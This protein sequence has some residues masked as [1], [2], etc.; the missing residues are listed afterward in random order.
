MCQQKAQHRH[1]FLI[2]GS[3][4]EQRGYKKVHWEKRDSGSETKRIGSTMFG[5]IVEENGTS[6]VFSCSGVYNL[7][8]QPTR[9]PSQCQGVSHVKLQKRNGTHWLQSDRRV[10]VDDKSSANALAG[11]TSVQVAPIQEGG[12]AS[13]SD[14]SVAEPLWNAA[15]AGRVSREAVPSEQ[16]QS[17]RAVEPDEWAVKVRAKPILET[18]TQRQR[19]IHELTH[20]YHLFLGVQHA[21]LEK[22][23]MILIRNSKTQE[24][25][26]W[27]L[28]RLIT[29]T[30][31]KRS[32]CWSSRSIGRTERR[33]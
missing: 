16:G 11:F 10:T 2:D 8:R 14:V 17:L 5:S 28:L 13:S 6:V 23:L 32:E 15:E 4:I 31:Q 24:I 1:C 22:P 26:D 30:F 19:D 21:C 20:T 3:P 29:V 33:H 9:P 27:T 18:R 25:L 7:I 12:A